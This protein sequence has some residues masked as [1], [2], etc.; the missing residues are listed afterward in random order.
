MPIYEYSCT[1]CHH[2]F[3]EWVKHHDTT[4]ST[5]CPVCG[6]EASHIVSNTSFVLKGGGWYVTEYGGKKDHEGAAPSPAEASTPA[7]DS[8]AE[9]QSAPQTPAAAPAAQQSEAKPQA[10]TEAPSASKTP[11]TAEKSAASAA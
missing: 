1:A 11:A 10:K 2:V 6:K 3:E 9:T 8:S 7:K 5:A 4:S